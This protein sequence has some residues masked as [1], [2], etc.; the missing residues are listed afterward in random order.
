MSNE[1][2]IAACRW[3]TIAI[4]IHNL[5]ID[6]EGAQSG[7]HFIRDHTRD[8]ELNDRGQQN[9]AIQIIGNSKRDRLIAE[10]VAVKGL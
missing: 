6:V 9:E 1:D 4:I 5:V 10:I 2:H 7:E 3:I 8:D